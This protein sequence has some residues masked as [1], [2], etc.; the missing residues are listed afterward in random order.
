MNTRTSLKRSPRIEE[1]K[2]W[3]ITPVV[4]R[5]IA[6]NPKQIG[7]WISGDQVIKDNHPSAFHGELLDLWLQAYEIAST[8]EPRHRATGREPMP[9][10]GLF[11][12]A[13]H[14]ELW[15]IASHNTEERLRCTKD[16]VIGAPICLDVT[17]HIVTEPLTKVFLER[18]NPIPYVDAI[19]RQAE[20]EMKQGSL[21]NRKQEQ[22]RKQLRQRIV[23]LRS[24]LE[25]G[26]KRKD[27]ILLEE[28]TRAERDLATLEQRAWERTRKAPTPINIDKVREFLWRLWQNWDGCPDRL[29]NEI[30]YL[31]MEGI[32]LC[33]ERKLVEA[34]I[35]WKSG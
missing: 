22:D 12:Y 19:L 33:H 14:G 10:A 30:V 32:E 9:F 34:T 13:N 31:F 35:V 29:K 18:F 4:I 24:S 27:E 3:A 6:T 16:Y 11:F 20:E 21:E 15:P 1:E 26:D 25:Y 5:G 28:I 17:E 7:F 8:D 23:N 2:G